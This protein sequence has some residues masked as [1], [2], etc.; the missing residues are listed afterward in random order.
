[1]SVETNI[2]MTDFV[3][4]RRGKRKKNDKEMIKKKM[5]KREVVFLL[6]TLL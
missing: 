1:M 6:W 2:Y 4:R 3:S 5:I